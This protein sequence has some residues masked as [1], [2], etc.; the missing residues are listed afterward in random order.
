MTPLQRWRLQLD[1]LCRVE[2]MSSPKPITG[3][4]RE[5]IQA[6]EADK[7]WRALEDSK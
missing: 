1:R 3:I 2:M 7:F 5:R 6:E 4:E